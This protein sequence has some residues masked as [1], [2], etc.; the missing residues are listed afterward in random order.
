MSHL[1]PEAIDSLERLSFGIREVFSERGH[2]IGVA[3]DRDPSFREGERGRSGLA[4]SMMQSAVATAVAAVDD[5]GL[6]TGEGG[7][8]VVRS[9]DRGYSRR[10]RV[11]SAKRHEGTFQ[12]L[13][14][15]DN[16]LR[17][18]KDTL[19]HEESWVLGYILNEEDQV[20]ELFIAQVLDRRDGNPGELILGP[21][22]MLM[23][24]PP[25]GDGGFQPTHEDLPMGEDDL[26]GEDED[27]AAK[28]G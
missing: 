18:D 7:V 26:D 16:I 22:Y 10:F 24:R 14:S 20:E 12:I 3:L 6:E 23:G 9:F 17:V 11:L 1:S 28:T 27:G 25:T 21:E 19:F 8:R 2:N 5:L 4:R 15:S 13:S